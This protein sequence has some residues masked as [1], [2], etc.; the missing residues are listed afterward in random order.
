M[1]LFGDPD[2]NPFNGKTSLGLNDMGGGSASAGF[3]MAFN[4]KT[5]RME[6]SS[7][8]AYNP[9][10]GRREVVTTPGSGQPT[11]PSGGGGGGGG[12]GGGSTTAATPPAATTTGAGA[13]TTAGAGAFY[14]QPW[15]KNILDGALAVYGIT[16]SGQTPNTYPVPPTPGEQASLDAKKGLFNYQSGYTDQ[17][18]RGMGNLNPDYKMNSDAVGDPS[19]MGGVKVPTIDWSKMPDR[20]TLGTAVNNSNPAAS[21]VG[22]QAAWDEIAYYG[23][24]AVETAKQ[25]N[26]NEGIPL[27]IVVQVIRKVFAQ[28]GTQPNGA[29][30]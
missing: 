27:P 18:L 14:N 15:F 16:R 26:Q 30:P 24:K 28:G 19:F 21:P 9:L 7:S 20:P 5:G 6:P 8:V 17:F 25:L 12:I 2:N 3:E 4:P 29:Q 13:A 22:D 23:A 1:D 11:R 10:T